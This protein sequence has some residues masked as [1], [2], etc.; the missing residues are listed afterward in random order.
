ML[1]IGASILQKI[2]ISL[3]INFPRCFYPANHCYIFTFNQILFLRCGANNRSFYP[4]NHLFFTNSFVVIVVALKYE[5][6][7][8]KVQIILYRFIFR[9]VQRSF[10]S[11]I[12]LSLQTILV[13]INESSQ[14]QSFVALVS[15]H[16]RKRL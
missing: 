16:C 4:A 2:I 8:C 9:D 10:L 1:I 5:L 7:S 11:N 15:N 13:R 3:Q 6:L 12:H 14:S